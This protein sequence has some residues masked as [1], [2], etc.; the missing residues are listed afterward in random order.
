MEAGDEE[1]SQPHVAIVPTPGMGHLFPLIEFTKRLVVQHNFLVTFIIAN[2]GKS[3]IELQ[4]KLLQSLPK[5]IS[6][7]FLPPI[8]LDDLPED[9]AIETRIELSLT[10]SLPSLRETLE[11]M[12]ES[13][14]LVSIVVDIFGPCT[15][16]MAKELGIPPYIYFP[17]TAM[18]L[19]FF[20]YLPKLDATTACE[21][22]DLPELV[23][24][25]GCFPV[26]GHKL[27]DVLQNRKSEPYK[28][29]VHMANRYYQADGIMVNSF[30]ELQPGAFKALKERVLGNPLVYSVGPMVRFG[31]TSDG[32]EK[33]ECLTWLDKQPTSSVLFV[34]FGTGGTL[35]QE[36][37]TQLALG[38]EKSGQRFVWVVKSPNDKSSSATYFSVQ[39]KQ[40]PLDFLPD[41]FL[42]RT[43]EVGLVV[44]S[45]APQ[46][47]IL[48][49]GS[50]G[51]F[52]TH[53]GWNS[54]LES[55]L[56]GVP[57]IA[58]PLFAE[59]K[60]N[61][62][63]VCE[64]LKVGLKAKKNEKGIVEDEEIAKLVRELME[65]EEGKVLRKKM[66]ELQEA[67]KVALSDEGSSTKTLAEVV[68][69]SSIVRPF[70]PNFLKFVLDCPFF[71]VLLSNSCNVTNFG[72]IIYQL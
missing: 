15:F 32:D 3:S 17:T 53:C 24:I 28:A 49:H 54:T 8:N 52:L 18:V 4:E 66:K 51:G 56:S 31:S 29:F 5:P 20:L 72:E 19:S 70:L 62:I 35:S 61:S 36:Q 69:F 6:Y 27:F 23:Q 45:W 59:Q 25:P 48:N 44:P 50:I 46:V 16:D 13:T 22:R 12:A 11:S 37:L 33:S 71:F 68:H 60:F 67:S 47:K 55:I 40:N 63:L 39:S 26:Q 57:L 42:E 30:F 65:G 1:R 10:R 41:G 58:W 34:S 2:D 64:E 43:K 14:Q 7:T 9:S 38:L 21:Y